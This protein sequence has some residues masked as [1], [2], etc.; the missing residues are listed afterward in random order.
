MCNEDEFMG[1]NNIIGLIEERKQH[2][3]I[4]YKT[5][6]DILMPSSVVNELYK[7]NLNLF[8]LLT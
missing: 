7:L 1:A 3:K 2:F 6:F 5:C 4:F 8:L